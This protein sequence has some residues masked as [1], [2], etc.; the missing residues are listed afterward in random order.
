MEI[1]ATRGR[2]A[3]VTAF[4]VE[5]AGTPAVDTGKGWPHLCH[6]WCHV[7]VWFVSRQLRAQGEHPP[8]SGLSDTEIEV[9]I[10]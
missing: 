4:V 9:G 10:H 8:F 2:A 7:W 5:S 3:Q 1:K 6:E